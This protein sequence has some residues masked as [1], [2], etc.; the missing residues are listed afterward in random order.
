MKAINC[1]VLF[2]WLGVVLV[3]V[4]GGGACDVEGMRTEVLILYNVFLVLFNK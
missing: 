1:E 3:C 2:P 4:C